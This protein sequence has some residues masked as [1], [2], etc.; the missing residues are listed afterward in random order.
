[1][2][3]TER[4]KQ[5]L[6]EVVD[7]YILTGEPVGSKA[8]EKSLSCSSATIRNEMSDLEALGL[9][10]HPHTSAGRVPTGRGYRMYVDTLMES[11]KLSFEESLLIHSHLTHRAENGTAFLDDTANLLS[12]LTGYASIAISRVPTGTIER[13]EGVYINP[14]SFLL[15]LITS[16]GRAVTRQFHLDFAMDKERLPFLMGLL[17]D[18]LAK[19]ELGG[20]TMER[21]AFLQKDLGDLGILTAPLIEMIYEMMADLSREHITVHGIGKLFAHPEFSAPDTVRA[22]LEEL[23]DENRL[24]HRYFTEEREGLKIRIG[25]DGEG[26]DRASCVICPILLREGT[27]GRICLVGPK[28]MNY[29]KAVARLED[30]AKRINAAAGFVSRVP[31]IET[32][33]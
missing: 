31:L 25:V 11:E 20:V 6:K 26:L 23:E 9:L 27:Q 16:A 33:G 30:L 21:I 8:I 5:I 24:S 13:F 3:L 7:A 14:A 12:D 4:K 18:H 22:V 10:D 29:A 17:N 1:M 32:K 2:E 28:R 19:K 15:I